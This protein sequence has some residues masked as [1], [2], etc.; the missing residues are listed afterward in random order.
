MS[1]KSSSIERDEAGVRLPPPLIFLVFLL[2]GLW[3]DSPWFEGEM[4]LPWQMGAGGV[5]AGIWLGVN[6]ITLVDHIKAGTNA[7]PWKPT[8]AVI[9]TGPYAWS[10]NPMYLG[11]AGVCSGIA[12]MGASWAALVLTVPAILIIHFH[13]IAREERYLEAKFGQVYQDYKAQVRTWI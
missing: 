11:M 2:S 8:T 9:T 7:E 13:V 6:L 10:R 12:F 1:D 4:T 3:I 5:W